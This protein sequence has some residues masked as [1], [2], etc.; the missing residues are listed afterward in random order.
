MKRFAFIGIFGILAACTD[1]PLS[2][3]FVPLR[4]PTAPV[5][6]QADVTLARLSGTWTVVEGAGVPPGREVTVTGQSLRFGT[7]PQPFVAL[8]S[9]RFRLGEAEVWVHW[10]DADNRTAAMGEPGGD[11][12]WIMDRTGKPGERLKAAREILEWYGYDMRRM[13]DRNDG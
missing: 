6:S 11:F 5:A 2:S 12:V 8:G 10:L 4:N 7:A 3:D 9:G 1:A 13:G